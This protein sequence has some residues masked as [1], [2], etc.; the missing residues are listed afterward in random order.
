MGIRRRHCNL[1]TKREVLMEE[2]NRAKASWLTFYCKIFSGFLELEGMVAVYL[3]QCL[4]FT[5]EI[6]QGPLN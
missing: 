2:R 6:L 3:A 4:Y 5:E 1:I